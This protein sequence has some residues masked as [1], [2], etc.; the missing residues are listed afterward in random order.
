MDSFQ[1]IYNEKFGVYPPEPNGFHDIFEVM[2]LLE[3][4]SK[5]AIDRNKILEQEEVDKAIGFDSRLNKPTVK[6]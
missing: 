2:K 4:L 6:F 1:E 5:L 3:K